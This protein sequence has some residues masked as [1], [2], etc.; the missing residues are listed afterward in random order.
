MKK[1]KL[2]FAVLAIVLAVGMLAGCGNGGGGGTTKDEGPEFILIGIP[3][4]ATGPIGSFG[5]GTPWAEQLVV[6]AVNADG[7]IYIEEFDRKIPIKIIVIDTESNPT[8]AAEVTQR[9][10]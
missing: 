8:K 7:G 1:K 10:S 2:I 9:L 5:I 3:N 6:D 4:P